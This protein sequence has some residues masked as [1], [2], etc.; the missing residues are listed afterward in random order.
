MD[1]TIIKNTKQMLLPEEITY[2]FANSWSH[3][4][5]VSAKF[6]YLLLLFNCLQNVILRINN[7]SN[8]EFKLLCSI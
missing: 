2:H 7:T 4:I 3:N 6:L 5:S 1:L 8:H